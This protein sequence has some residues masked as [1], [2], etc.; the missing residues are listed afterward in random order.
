ME[1]RHGAYEVEDGTDSVLRVKHV[2]HKPRHTH[3]VDRWVWCGGHQPPHP[4]RPQTIQHTP[5]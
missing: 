4:C 5:L 3:R 1:G 2:E